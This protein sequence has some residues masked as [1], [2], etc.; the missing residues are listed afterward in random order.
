MLR[1]TSCGVVALLLLSTLSAWSQSGR[2]AP[3]LDDASAALGISRH[4]FDSRLVGEPVGYYLYL[5]QDYD[6]NDDIR[7]PVVYWLHGL[8][9]SPASAQ[10]IVKRMPDAIRR[11]ETPPF[12]V[13]SC[14]DKT[15][16]TMWTDAKDGSVP[17]ESVIVN[18]LIAHIDATY[19]T[20]AERSFRGVGG[21]SM[22]GF[23][24]AYLGF[25][26]PDVFGAVSIFAGALHSA[27]SLRDNRRGIFDGVYDGDLGLATRLSPWTV[28]VDNASEIRDRTHVRIFVGSEDGLL[29]RNRH[30]HELLDQLGIEHD[31][32][33]VPNVGHQMDPLL[34]SW[35][36]GSPFDF[37]Q[38]AFG[39]LA[40]R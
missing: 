20:R 16:R 3:E 28:V 8:G 6:D 15:S 32:G 33:V 12:I 27:E 10:A 26:Y 2:W 1:R 30:Y 11:G 5:P 21:F 34:A 13:V 39:A 17:V 38:A 35:P 36:K 25:K 31:W 22:G 14:T 24:A 37:Y 23:G 18:E 4:A 9:G 19:R 7:Y 29:E 40:T